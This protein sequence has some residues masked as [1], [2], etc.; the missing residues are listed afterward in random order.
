MSE[1][2]YSVRYDKFDVQVFKSK[3]MQVLKNQSKLPDHLKDDMFYV[4]FD[5]VLKNQEKEGRLIQEAES[6]ISQLPARRA[7]VFERQRPRQ[8]GDKAHR[9]A[10]SVLF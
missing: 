3:K 4:R 9:V 8:D 7:A 10:K 5:Q 1:K 6:Q 2:M